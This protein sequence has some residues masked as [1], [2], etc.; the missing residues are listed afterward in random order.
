[1]KLCLGGCNLIL[2]I[3]NRFLPGDGAEESVATTIWRGL[4]ETRRTLSLGIL[5]SPSSYNH[6][7]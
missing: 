5:D 7:V 2:R 4:S 3:P 6:G 1:M